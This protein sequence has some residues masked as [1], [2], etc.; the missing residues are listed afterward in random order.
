MLDF[1]RERLRHLMANAILELWKKE[2]GSLTSVLIEGTIC[3]TASSG[4]TTVVQVSDRF[5]RGLPQYM[6]IEDSGIHSP[7]FTRSFNNGLEKSLK[8][9]ESY[10]AKSEDA[11]DT[12]VVT[13]THSDSPSAEGEA[14][15]RSTVPRVKPSEGDN[16]DQH[17][18]VCPGTGYYS[19][20]TG[21]KEGTAAQDVSMDSEEEESEELGEGRAPTTSTPKTDR[22]PSLGRESPADEEDA[23]DLSRGG[24]RD[25]DLALSSPQSYTAQVRDVI[26]QR[27]L[28]HKSS[29]DSPPVAPGER[30]PSPPPGPP[31][32]SFSHSWPGASGSTPSLF[33]AGIPYPS[34]LT[35]P[36]AIGLPNGPVTSPS[37]LQGLFSFPIR[38]HAF[39]HG[40]S[41]P[42][43]L[44]TKPPPLPSPNSSGSPDDCMNPVFPSPNSG[45]TTPDPTDVNGNMEK[46]PLT[47]EQKVYKCEFCSKT[48][49]FKSKYHE[50]LPVHTNARPFKCHLCSRT[51]KY[52]Y[53][54]RVHL[55]THMGIPTKSTVCPFCSSKFSTNKI[56]RVHIRDVHQDRST[57]GLSD[58]PSP[59]AGLS[60][61]TATSPGCSPHASASVWN[62]VHPGKGHWP[63]L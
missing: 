35:P 17:G 30:T 5:T 36:L 31:R 33:P 57:S 48:F 40:A 55:R 8:Y 50:H 6:H 24:R 47:G 28:A 61:D 21:P 3:I 32:R 20:E 58:C 37:L 18:A 62:Q 53:D 1:Q 51:Y 23:L 26:R 2:T 16:N 34:R 59:A 60:S 11:S 29:E 54:L 46:D 52:K 39:P 15:A 27:L 44:S 14:K 63:C 10:V 19:E 9:N 41:L 4:K 42:D 56:L 13:K 12:S 49:L 45:K 25:I 43:I 38:A 22:R 7:D